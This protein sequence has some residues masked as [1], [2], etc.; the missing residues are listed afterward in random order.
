MHT[1]SAG[2]GTQESNSRQAYIVIIHTWSL[3]Y[4]REEI[5]FGFLESFVEEW[6]LL[7]PSLESYLDSIDHSMGAFVVALTI[8]H[9][10]CWAVRRREAQ[11]YRRCRNFSAE[12]HWMESR[13]EEEWD[14]VVVP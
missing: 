6:K 12:L 3:D 13:I 2:D 9:T 8:S 11:K 1:L 5:F 7:Y 4:L 10:L 14:E